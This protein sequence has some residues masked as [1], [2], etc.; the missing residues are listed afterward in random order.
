MITKLRLTLGL[1]LLAPAL[2]HALGLGD[3][4]LGSGLNQPMSADIEIVGASPEDLLQLR[5]GLPARE[6]FTR[7]GVDRPAYLSGFTFT[8]GKDSGGRA[9]LKVRSG[10]PVTEPFVTFL[11]EVTWP[12]GHLIRE[13]TALLDPPVFENK[14]APAAP[15]AA[16][17]TGETTSAAAG[18]VVRAPA[19]TAPAAT[20]PAA[21][22]PATPAAAEAPTSVAGG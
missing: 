6:M 7:Y 2:A 13:Y 10:D 4:R 8:I 11:V 5:A 1:L 3:M 21:T 19:P 22:P 20:P 18:A 15:V 14:Q 9:I 12:R 17:Q 16:P